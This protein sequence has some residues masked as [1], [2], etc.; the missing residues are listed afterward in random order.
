LPNEKLEQPLHV[1]TPGKDKEWSGLE[2]G[3]QMLMARGGRL[4]DVDED[5]RAAFGRLLVQPGVALL[6]NQLVEEERLRAGVPMRLPA[7]AAPMPSAS[8]LPPYSVQ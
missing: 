1:I 2:H 5:G 8:G 4:R 3:I 7:T 6:V